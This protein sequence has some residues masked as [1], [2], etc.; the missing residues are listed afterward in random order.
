MSGRAAAEKLK[1]R[2]QNAKT[3]LQDA[4]QDVLSGPKVRITSPSDANV[5]GG[6]DLLPSSFVHDRK[7]ESQMG[8][9]CRRFTDSHCDGVVVGGVTCVLYLRDNSDEILCTGLWSYDGG[10][11]V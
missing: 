2:A 7:R 9:Q 8:R 4:G 3:R 6:G 11:G 10:L 5:V 1:Q